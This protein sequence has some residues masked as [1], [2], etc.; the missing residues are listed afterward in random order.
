ML[1][2]YRPTHGTCCQKICTFTQLYNHD[3]FSIVQF[4]ESSSHII[5]LK[6]ARKIMC[7]Y[8]SKEKNNCKKS[9]H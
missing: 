4:V 2:A 6:T 1:R 7:S 8:L 3:R 5:I 9:L